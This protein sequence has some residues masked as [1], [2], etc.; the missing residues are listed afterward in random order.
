[1]SGGGS[2]TSDQLSVHKG[3]GTHVMITGRGRITSVQA[4]GHAS[5]QLEFHDCAT[6]GDASASNEVLRLLVEPTAPATQLCIE[7]D[8]HGILFKTGISAVLAGTGNYTVVF[9]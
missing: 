5:G 9:Q 3:S 8:T 2:F 4:K 7:Q 6:T 1:M